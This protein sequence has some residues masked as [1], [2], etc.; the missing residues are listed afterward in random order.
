MPRLFQLN[1]DGTLDSSFVLNAPDWRF[2]ELVM[3][4][5]NGQILISVLESAFPRTSKL[6]RL[7]SDGSVDPSFQIGRGEQ[8]GSVLTQADG[9]FVVSGHFPIYNGMPV[10]SI[11]QLNEDGSVDGNFQSGAG[12]LNSGPERVWVELRSLPGGQILALGRFD[13]YDGTPVTDG[14]VL[15]SDGTLDA[16]AF[17]RESTFVAVPGIDELLEVP[18]LFVYGEFVGVAPSTDNPFDFDQGPFLW[19]GHGQNRLRTELALRIVSTQRG[20]DGTTQL[21]ANG[22][23]DRSYTLQ[24]S[25]N[26]ANWSD[27]ATQVATTNRIKFT[28]APTNS[29]AVRFFRLKSN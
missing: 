2:P 19:L 23:I 15:N 7:N 22:L 11:V 13:S 24:A 20:S 6:F 9:K 5:T 26:L 8:I 25:E 4:Q 17:T 1:N 21:L 16:T 28:D 10:N 18:A 27:L 3:P 12:F 14:A 29:P